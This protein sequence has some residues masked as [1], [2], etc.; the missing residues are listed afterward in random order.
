MNIPKLSS[1]VMR[2]TFARSIHAGVVPAQVMLRG[3]QKMAPVAGGTAPVIIFMTTS[4]KGDDSSVGDKNCSEV[5]S[6]GDTVHFGKC[7]NVCKG[8]EVTK[9]YGGEYGGDYYCSAAFG[10]GIN[11]LPTLEI[12]RQLATEF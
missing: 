2:T 12:L 11:R 10:G 4:V 7:K 8:K 9:D 5:N 6:N 3:I 1:G